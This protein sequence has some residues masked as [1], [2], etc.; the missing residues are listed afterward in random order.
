MVALYNRT[1]TF[2]VEK[3]AR[4]KSITL[5]ITRRIAKPNSMP[6]GA[7]ENEMLQKERSVTWTTVTGEVSSQGQGI[8]YEIPV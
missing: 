8:T 2:K 1:D 5:K 4:V 3:T 6:G 7:L